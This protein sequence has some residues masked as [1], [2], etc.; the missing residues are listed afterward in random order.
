M[1]EREQS[2]RKE[3]ESCGGI[4]SGVLVSLSFSAHG[5]G[6]SVLWVVVKGKQ[7][8]RPCA[9]LN[10]PLSGLNILHT[11]LCVLGSLVHSAH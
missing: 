10:R 5:M 6:G 7:H 8:V 4:Y 9:N 2:K 11:N 1:R 3:S